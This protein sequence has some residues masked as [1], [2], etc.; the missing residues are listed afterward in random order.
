MT[1]GVKPGRRSRVKRESWLWGI[2]MS[3]HIGLTIEI[4]HV[5]FHADGSEQS[6]RNPSS[7]LTYLL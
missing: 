7:Y 1:D 3:R 6:S 2:G 5:D 4:P